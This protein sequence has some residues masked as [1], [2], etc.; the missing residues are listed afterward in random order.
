MDNNVQILE[1]EINR[2]RLGFV[3]FD[4][5][6]SKEKAKLLER[7]TSFCPE[8]QKILNAEI[9]EFNN[10]VFM[11]K[12]CCGYKFVVLKERDVEF[13]KK[14]KKFT[15]SSY[16]PSEITLEDVPKFINYLS[17]IMIHINEKCNTFCGI[18]VSNS[19]VGDWR[20]WEEFWTLEKIKS[21][22][23]T[24][25][26]KERLILFSGG[27][28]TMREDLPEIIKTTINS[29]NIPYVFTNGVKFADKE[30]AKL[31]KSAG[32][33]M[34]HFTLDSLTPEVTAAFNG[35]G[36]W[37]FTEKM[38]ALENLKENGF[39]VYLSCKILKEINDGE[40][41]SLL[42][43]AVDNKDFVS[44]ITFRPFA[45]QGRVM[46]KVKEP[47]TLSEMIKM[48]EE[49]TNGIITEEYLL[50][51][52]RF[53]FNTSKVVRKLFG[54]KAP[55]NM[56]MNHYLD[57]LLDVHGNSVKQAI[58]LEKLKELNEEIEKI[59][60][61]KKSKIITSLVKKLDWESI[62]IASF[63]FSNS[64]NFGKMLAKASY[65]NNLVRVIFSELTT[66]INIDFSE[67]FG[68]YTTNTKKEN[69]IT[70]PYLMA[71]YAMFPL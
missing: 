46:L 20:G 41:G 57:C 58:S 64:F 22:L 42:K 16:I 51:F 67:K 1:T 49:Q 32:L 17:S 39:G 43:W 9:Y 2:N 26:N 21:F 65:K 60:T 70:K 68:L 59:I 30:Y 37:I 19:N 54:K 33:K 36:K 62:K 38:K 52:R 48:A 40:I 24:I 71:S 56:S 44:G 47:L 53:R 27:E 8:C 3:Q 34:L 45:P 63:A 29:G 23:N 5:D 7:V 4:Y 69:G 14:L 66:D 55:K 12:E 11:Y 35:G 50:E 6:F 31:L 18:C 13:Y 28:P 25:K 15:E 10:Q 61:E